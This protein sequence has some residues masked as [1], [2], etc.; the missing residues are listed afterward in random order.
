MLQAQLEYLNYCKQTGKIIGKHDASKTGIIQLLQANWKKY[1]KLQNWYL[2]II[3][4][5]LE[6]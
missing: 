5:K 4:S 6:K 1:V 2:S 3:G